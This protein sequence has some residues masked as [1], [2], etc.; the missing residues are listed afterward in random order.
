MKMIDCSNWAQRNKLLTYGYSERLAWF[1]YKLIVVI[2]HGAL[3]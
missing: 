3:K 2:Y 1:Y